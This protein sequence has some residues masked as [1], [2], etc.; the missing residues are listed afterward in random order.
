MSIP[1]Q[2]E[3]N[4]VTANEPP[5]YI[6]PACKVG[7]TERI[8][9]GVIAIV[10]AAFALSFIQTDPLVAAAAGLLAIGVAAMAITGWCAA[11]WLSLR[12]AAAEPLEETHDFADARA[13]S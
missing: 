8:I 10:M 6:R 12:G 4:L 11:T 9:R 1:T 2:D 13:K 3:T 5:Q 7:V